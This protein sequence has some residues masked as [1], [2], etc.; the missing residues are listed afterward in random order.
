M[1]LFQKREFLRVDHKK[2]KN[3]GR[4]RKRESQCKLKILNNSRKKYIT[5]LGYWTRLTKLSVSIIRYLRMNLVSLN[6]KHILAIIIIF[7][8]EIFKMPFFSNFNSIKF[9]NIFE[10]RTYY[11]LNPYSKTTN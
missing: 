7:K 4:D 1:K 5:F 2:M 8:I 11:K 3:W 10:N 6:F 9:I